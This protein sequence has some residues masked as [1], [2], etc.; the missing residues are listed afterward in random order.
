MI[1]RVEPVAITR[2]ACGGT[3]TA[4][5]LEEEARAAAVRRHN[6]TPLHVEWSVLRGYQPIPARWSRP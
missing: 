6:V 3:L 1:G 5:G 4:Y 2:C